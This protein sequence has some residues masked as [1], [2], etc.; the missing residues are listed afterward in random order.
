MTIEDRWRPHRYLLEDLAGRVETEG[1]TILLMGKSGFRAEELLIQGLVHSMEILLQKDGLEDWQITREWL[2][3]GTDSLTLGLGPSRLQ[4]RIDR[5]ARIKWLSWED[6][7]RRERLC[8][9]D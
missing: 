8:G 6:R 3:D 4:L 7:S 5:K 9:S 1:H 2:P